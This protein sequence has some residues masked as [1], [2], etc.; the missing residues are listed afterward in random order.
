[1][2]SPLHESHLLLFRNQPTLAAELIRGALHVDVPVY[3][4]ARVVSADLTDMQPAEYRADMVI[5]LF[6]DAPVFGIV[7]EVQLS[8]DERKRFVWPAYVANLRARLECPVCLLVVTADDAVARWAA[9]SVDMGGLHRF[10]PYVLSP[11]GIPEITNEDDARAN[12]E[13]AVLSAMAH[14]RGEDTERSARIATAAQSASAGLDAD[15]SKLY[16]DLIISSLSEAARQAL[17]K[18]D[19]HSYE[20]QSD[21]ARHYVA[22]GQA[23][24][25]VALVSRLLSVR[26]GSLSAEIQSQIS[27]ASVAELDAMG[28]RLLTARTLYEVLGAR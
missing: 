23:E 1:M 7:V 15:R 5:Q 19:A 9:R 11:S 21:F 10:A 17:K 28:E 22:Q 8:A 6:D 18:M 14:G 3:K 20:Y 26:F 13:L 27:K 16:F 24:G 2:P 12:P 4:E 25:R